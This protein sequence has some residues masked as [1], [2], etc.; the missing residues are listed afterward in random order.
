MSEYFYN[1]VL[2]GKNRGYS[3]LFLDTTRLYSFTRFRLEDGNTVT[4]IF[5]LKLSGRSIL[6][7]QHGDLDWVDFSG[8]PKNHFPGCAYPLLL[9]QALHQPVNYIQVSED[10]G[11]VIGETQLRPEPPDIVESF[12]G[13]V[14]RTFTMAGATPVQINWGGAVSHLCADAEECVRDSGIAFVIDQE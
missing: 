3:Y 13:V 11:S 7:C 4:N 6:A 8:H 1:F 12:R 5:K 9:P 14:Q 10:D 2:Q